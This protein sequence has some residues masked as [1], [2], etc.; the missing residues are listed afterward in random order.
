M[1]AHTITINQ[2]DHI[3]RKY[4]EID[5]KS[6]IIMNSEEEYIKSFLEIFIEAIKC[7]LRSAFPIG[8]ELSGGLDSSSVVCMAKKILNENK[9]ISNKY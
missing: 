8:F 1:H 7:R 3:N 5:P 4:W 9:N 2:N 6:K